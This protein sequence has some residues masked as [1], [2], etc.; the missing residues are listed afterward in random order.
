VKAI[1]S[2]HIQIG[3]GAHPTSCIM[4]QHISVLGLNWP[5][6][7]ND[8]PHLSSTEVKERAAQHLHSPIGLQG[9]LYGAFKIVVNCSIV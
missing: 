4:G 3:S 9:L 2:T 8:H 6:S 5:G 1:F 7:G